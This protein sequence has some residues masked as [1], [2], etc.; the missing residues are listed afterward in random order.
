MSSEARARLAALMA[1][2]GSDGVLY[3]ESV[4][5]EGVTAEDADQD[6]PASVLDELGER[7]SAYNARRRAFG[8]LG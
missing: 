3:I 1:D 5:V 6:P 8:G 4:P 2:H 7:V